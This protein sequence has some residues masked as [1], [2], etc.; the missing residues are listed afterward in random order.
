LSEL[1]IGRT[2]GS[3]ENVTFWVHVDAKITY[4]LFLR[5]GV[6]AEAW[7]QDEMEVG[8][9]SVPPSV[10]SRA[11][12]T[13]P[14]PAE[15]TGFA[16]ELSRSGCDGTC[17]SYSVVIHGDGKVEF[18][19]KHYVGDPCRLSAV[20]RCSEAVGF[21]LSFSG[22]QFCPLI[23][24]YHASVLH[25]FSFG[26]WDDLPAHRSSWAQSRHKLCSKPALNRRKY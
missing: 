15:P 22:N 18:H 24:S 6:A 9:E 11:G 2:Q 23:R 19:G 10:L 20:H 16:I 3:P 14:T 25:G 26:C 8:A 17:P 4:R 21:R 1:R 7:V 5:N 13:F 12:A